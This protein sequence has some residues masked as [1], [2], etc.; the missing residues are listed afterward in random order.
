MKLG[1]AII[2]D[3]PTGL[4]VNCEDFDVEFLG[5]CDYEYTYRFDKS[6]RDRLW[7]LLRAN[8]LGGSMEDMIRAY[9]GACLEK[10]PFGGFCDA[11]GIRYELFTWV[12]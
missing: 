12:S 2:C 10:R 9:F 3:S 4:S 7:T 11:N 5:G 8:G 6:N 1:Y